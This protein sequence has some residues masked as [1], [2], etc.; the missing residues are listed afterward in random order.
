MPSQAFVAE[1]RPQSP[2]KTKWLL[3]DNH[4]PEMQ[5]SGSKSLISNH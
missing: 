1:Q 4:R 2:D 3:N 5:Q